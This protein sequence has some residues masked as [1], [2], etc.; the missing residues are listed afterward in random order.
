[1]RPS[2]FAPGDVILLFLTFPFDFKTN[3]PINM[4][5][6]VCLDYTPQDVLRYADPPGLA[7]FVLPGYSV[8]PGLVNCC[9]RKPG[10]N[11][12]PAG[13]AVSDGMFLSL[14]ALRLIAPLGIEIAGQFELTHEKERI[15]S[16]KLYLLRSPWQPKSENAH[17]YSATSVR[18]AC[19]VANRIIA[20]RDAKRLMSAQVLFTQ[21]TLGMTSSLQL[22]TMGLFAALEALFVPKGKIARELAKRTANFLS[23]VG[24]PV[25]ITIWLEDEYIYR[26]NSLAHGIQ[27][28]LAWRWKAV[29]PEK[30]VVFGRLHELVRLSLLGFLS[31]PDEVIQ[32]HSS[33]TGPGLQGFLDGLIPVDGEFSRRQKAWCE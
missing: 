1:M 4:G 6:A 15:G 23:P 28:I 27:D 13:M 3:L 12:L 7:D 29:N 9:L 20:L 30:H 33:L 11:A 22:A 19:R 31:L 8:V 24:F 25:E 5:G 2:E 26:R 21:V 32:N 16:P 14:A 10:S 17:K 18:R